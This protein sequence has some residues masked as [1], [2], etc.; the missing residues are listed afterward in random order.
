MVTT[1]GQITYCCQA[2]QVETTPLFFRSSLDIAGLSLLWSLDDRTL[3]K[4]AK[5][6]GA[7]G[8]APGMVADADH[9][10][11]SLESKLHTS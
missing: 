4:K 8:L 10:I 1:A 5:V 11:F 9:T 3:T 6:L 2:E 7:D